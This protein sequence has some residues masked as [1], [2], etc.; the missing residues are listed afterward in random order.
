MEAQYRAV[1]QRAQAKDSSAE[2]NL[3]ISDTCLLFLNNA[4]NKPS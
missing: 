4:N 3:V 1:F 2:V